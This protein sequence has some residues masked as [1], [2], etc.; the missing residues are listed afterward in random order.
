MTP[1]TIPPCALARLPAGVR[2]VPA[3]FSTQ[4]V[5][6]DGPLYSPDGLATRL[7]Q[8]TGQ[9]ACLWNR[10]AAIFVLFPHLKDWMAI[11]PGITSSRPREGKKLGVTRTGFLREPER[12]RDG[13]QKGLPKSVSSRSFPASR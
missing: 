8:P 13:V 1:L 9:P 10:T 3:H 7:Y 12:S 11:L 5:R 2:E 6:L 4:Q